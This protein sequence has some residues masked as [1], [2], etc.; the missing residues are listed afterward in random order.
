MK[1]IIALALVV[2]AT[3]Y[4]FT[5]TA[6]ASRLPPTPWEVVLEDYNRVFI[7]TPT[8]GQ[9][10]FST[11]EIVWERMFEHD[12]WEWIMEWAWEE[13][14]KWTAQ[15]SLSPA[16][17]MGIRSGLYYNTYPL[18]NIYYVYE[19]IYPGGVHFSSDGMFFVHVQGIARGFMPGFV[20]DASEDLRGEAV[21]V[22]FFA[23]GSLVR[24]YRVGDLLRNTNR[25]GVTP[26]GIMWMERGS[27]EFNQQ[28]NILSATTV[29]GRLY[30]FDITTGDIIRQ[31]P[32]ALTI[33]A[34]IVL[35]AAIVLLLRKRAARKHGAKQ[36][37]IKK[38]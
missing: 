26:E 24:S 12:D 30:T 9:P 19:Y 35:I 37:N 17:R 6:Y 16:E 32:P 7:M 5:F 27:L 2:C 20:P 21:A 36:S 18:V 25:A 38:H 22:R 33:I 4:A 23:N 14:I 13:Q 29:D 15:H 8:S 10:C 28:T 34:G 3:V 1:K 31:R 11:H